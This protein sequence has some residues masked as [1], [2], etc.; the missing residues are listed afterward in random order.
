MSPKSPGRLSVHS[1]ISAK[2]I[3]LPREMTNSEVAKLFFSI[4]I[5]T[6][7]QNALGFILLII[8]L[9]FVG[10][11]N[12]A[13]MTAGFGLATTFIHVCGMSLMIGTNCTQETLTSQAFGAGELV[14]CGILLN[15]GRL[16]LL[17]MSVPISLLF[18]FSK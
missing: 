9:Y 14:R 6:L 8:N 2:H 5:P 1:D 7:T 16:I 11:L 18:L 13:A 4:V 3:T 12:N 15:R 17:A 10:L